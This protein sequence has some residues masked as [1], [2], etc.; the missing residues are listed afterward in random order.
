MFDVVG[1]DGWNMGDDVESQSFSVEF[2]RCVQINALNG[3]VR[4]RLRDI[5]SARKVF[6]REPG[7][8]GISDVPASR[9]YAGSR[10]T[11]FPNSCR[12]ARQ[13]TW[14]RNRRAP[15]ALRLFETEFFFGEKILVSVVHFLIVRDATRS[16][17]VRACL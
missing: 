7:F 14:N 5:A 17:F 10:K 11:R 9:L 2:H 13:R 6:F 4:H 3:S 8:P 1:S 15:F 16:D 12:R